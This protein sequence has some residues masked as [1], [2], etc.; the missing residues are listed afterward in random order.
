MRYVHVFTDATGRTRLEDCET[1]FTSAPFAPPAPPLD[2]SAVEPV[3]GL[4]FIRFP[5]GWTDPAHPAPARQ[6]MFVLSGR[7]ESTVDGATRRWGPGSVF[8]LEDTSGP[9]HGTTAFDDTVMAV[10]RC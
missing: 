9:G 2:V 6:W 3:D 8:F 4:L 1:S 5:A 10:V 7:G